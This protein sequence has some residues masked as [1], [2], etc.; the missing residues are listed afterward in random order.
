MELLMSRTNLSIAIVEMVEVVNSESVFKNH[1]RQPYCLQFQ[2][3]SFDS[4]LN[5]TKKDT[6]SE[7]IF[8]FVLF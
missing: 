7:F 6:I 5:V 4:G 2:D 3:T 1:S 8:D